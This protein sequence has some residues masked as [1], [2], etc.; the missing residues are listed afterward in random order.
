MVSEAGKGSKQRPT[1]KTKYDEGYDRI[2]K[3]DTEMK[4]YDIQVNLKVEAMSELSAEQHVWD[5]FKQNSTELLPNNI[6]GWDWLEF[7]PSEE[8]G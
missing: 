2:F 5:F 1:D 3:K 7:V 4:L 8:E 6:I